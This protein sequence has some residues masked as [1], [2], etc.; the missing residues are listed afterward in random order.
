MTAIQQKEQDLFVNW[1]PNNIKSSVCSVAPN[2]LK[3]TGTFIGI[4]CDY[5]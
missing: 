4:L 2:G 5:Y 3:R 1:I